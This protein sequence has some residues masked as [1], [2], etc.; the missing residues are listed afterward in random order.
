MLL[1]LLF[2]IL[3]GE[4]ER[5]GCR[6]LTHKFTL[7][8]LPM[9]LPAKVALDFGSHSIKVVEL[10][11]LSSNAKLVGFGSYP[12]PFGVISSENEEYQKQLANA[13]KEAIKQA[14]L[15]TKYA[16]AA[17]PE[18]SIFSRLIDMTKVKDDE[19]SE[20]KY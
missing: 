16:I 17:L 9:A 8:K 3:S 12:T 19:M 4:C 6:C 11:D 1:L 7:S 15:K 18:S 20:A 5:H 14:G 2:I 10:G 13:V